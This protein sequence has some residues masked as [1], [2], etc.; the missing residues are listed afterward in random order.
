LINTSFS[1]D[2]ITS[3]EMGVSLVRLNGG[4]IDKPYV[5]GKEILE[6][7]PNN[8]LYPYFFGIKYQPLSFSF[9]ITCEDLDMD[10]DRLF[11]IANWICQNEYK[12]LIFDD[13]PSIQYYCMVVNQ[14]G[15]VTNGLSQGYVE[16]EFRCRDGFGWTIPVIEEFDFTGLGDTQSFQ[17]KSLTNILDYYYPE[18]EFELTNSNTGVSIVNISDGGR[19]TSLTGL[20]ATEEIYMDGQKRILLSNLSSNR[21]SNFNN[22]F[23]RLKKGVNNIELT[24]ECIFRV[25]SQFPV[26]I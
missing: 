17:L 13:N 8:S 2:G 18:I 22:K 7:F 10:S 4:M 12:P 21:F 15:F 5:S 11:D 6:Q 26:Y 24:G 20:I 3:D 1:Y 25:R 23:L 16:L 19:E 14:A 9:A